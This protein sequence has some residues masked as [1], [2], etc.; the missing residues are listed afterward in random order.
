MSP[1]RPFWLPPK[2]SIESRLLGTWGVAVSGPVDPS[3]V[4]AKI[5]EL[6]Q[7][8]ADRAQTSLL[9]KNTGV[10]IFFGQPR[11]ITASEIDVDGQ[12]IT[13]QDIVITTG[14]SPVRSKGIGLENVNYY[15][16]QE[17]FE[18]QCN[19]GKFGD[20]RRWTDRR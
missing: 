14:S 19:S 4:L 12:R 20:H 10:E 11:F 9:L 6:R 3:G 18:N 1:P 7:R 5:R 8:A 17:I 16:N 15:T 13:G 2:R